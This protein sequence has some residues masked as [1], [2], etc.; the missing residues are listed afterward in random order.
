[1]FD[2]NPIRLV[3]VLQEWHDV[4]GLEGAHL[5]EKKKKKV[6]LVSPRENT[7]RLFLAVSINANW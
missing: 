3:W 6:I 7:E 1:M 4:K 2:C 5:K